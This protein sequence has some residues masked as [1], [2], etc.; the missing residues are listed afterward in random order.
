MVYPAGRVEYLTASGKTRP[1][2]DRATG[3]GH[4]KQILDLLTAPVY[5][6]G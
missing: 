1:L 4:P 5:E 2:V 3:L 6:R